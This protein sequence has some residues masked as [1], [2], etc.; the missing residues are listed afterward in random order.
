V[1]DATFIQAGKAIFTVEIPE[2]HRPEGAKPHYTFKVTSKDDRIKPNE[3]I[4]FLSMLT[5][6]DNTSDYSYIGILKTDGSVK[7]TGASRMTVDSYPVK[8]AGRVIPRLLSGDVAPMLALGFDVHHEGRCCRCGR[9]L[10]TPESIKA[11]I[12]P[13]CAGRVT[14]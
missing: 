14:E 9:K 10:T 3:K 4:R 13:E 7:L 12:G 5:G 11:G 6:P 1:I 2:S 8:L